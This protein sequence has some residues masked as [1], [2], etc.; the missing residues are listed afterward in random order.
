VKFE[1]KQVKQKKEKS[2]PQKIAEGKTD[3]QTVPSDRARTNRGMPKG[4]GGRRKRR[5]LKEKKKQ[6]KSTKHLDD[7][8]PRRSYRDQNKRRK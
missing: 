1:G 7:E 2:K 8:G 3:S 5:G 4:W 6:I